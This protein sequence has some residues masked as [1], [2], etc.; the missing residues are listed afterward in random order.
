MSENYSP[1]ELK[2][3]PFMNSTL[4]I[5]ERVEDLL[6]R[7]TFEEKVL[8]SAG[9]GFNSPP[10]IPRLGIP[11]FSM[12]DGPAGVSPGAAKEAGIPSFSATLDGAAT[13]GDGTSTYFPT[14]IQLA[15][16]WNPALFFQ[17]GQA[18]G[19]EI[20]AVGRVMDLGPAINICRSPMNG[21]TFEYYS[22]DPFLAGKLAVAVV[23]GLQSKRVAPCVKHFA[24][25]NQETRRFM[26][27]ANVSRRA[28]EEI[29][30]PAFR[31]CVEE[32]DAW[33]FMSSYNKINGVYVSENKVVMRDTLMDQWGFKGIVVSD[34]GASKR[35]TGPKT[36]IEA[37]LSIEMA[38]REQF[39][40]EAMQALKASGEFPEKYFEDN[41]RRILRVM[42][43]VGQFD[44]P[45][46]IP[47]GSINSKEHQQLARK[48]AE[49]GMV[50][51]KN[52]NHLLPLDITKI[53]KIAI[54]G[55]H[56]DLKFGRRKLGGGSSAVFPP[57]EI[58]VREGIIQ[59]T[60]GRA[61]IV[62]NPAEADVAVVCI[63]LEHSHDF[64]GGDHEGSDKL[65]YG[66]GIFLPKLVNKTLAAN[67]N[68]VVVF[69]GGSPSGMEKFVTK[70]PA[71][72]NAWYGGMEIGNVVA[73]ILFGDVNPSG[74]LPVT[75]PKRKKDIPTALSFLQTVIG[76]KEVNYNE[77][78]FVGYRYYD[79]H[80]VE[81]RFYFG[82]GL[83][84]TIFRYENLKLSSNQISGSQKLTVHLDLINTGN[85]SGAEVVQLYV[86]DVEAVV[87]RPL[88]ELKGFQKVHLEPGEK[89]SLSLE[90]SRRDLSYF[91]EKSN[92]WVAKDGNFE[93]LLGSSSKEIRLNGIFRY[94]N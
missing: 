36:L 6:G 67:P 38:G 79:A 48:L 62:A 44:G 30:F 82:H 92:T 1:E 47:K 65:R 77:G 39:T 83:S 74:K 34:W 3:L 61:E 24:A 45:A 91:D 86:R 31:M 25:N 94:K 49:E 5:E 43:L 7:L 41:V 81:P 71:V 50:L 23:K 19:E 11:R 57:Y 29:Y 12:T 9:G 68:T 10:P 87:P 32:A 16:T 59:K 72:L 66:L 78:V 64:K 73:D 8:L 63:G 42:I 15:S 93:V 84:Y 21:R 75:W 58:T 4:P 89:K 52:E 80:K 55:R 35:V 56:A 53:K 40:L 28:L 76:V 17:F 37:G 14:G 18:L 70:V 69:V 85:R 2:K 20:R 13:V 90:L 22:E 54:L 51:L 46:S 26:V 88:K 60:K 27:S 33:G